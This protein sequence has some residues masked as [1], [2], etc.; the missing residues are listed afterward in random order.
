MNDINVCLQELEYLKQISDALNPKAGY[1]G[2]VL[3]WSYVQIGY[4]FFYEKTVT[5]TGSAESHDIIFPK[6]IQL[7][8][9]EQI[10]NDATARDFSIRMMTAGSTSTYVELRAETADT[11]LNRI[12]QAGI[13]Y[14]YPGG[15]RLRMYYANTT[16]GKTV[17]IRVQVDEL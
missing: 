9:I 1:Q 4:V 7:N 6:A 11:G 12:T 14:K 10:W 15:S 5:Y 3:G 16:A 17:T 13:E 2:S 8:R